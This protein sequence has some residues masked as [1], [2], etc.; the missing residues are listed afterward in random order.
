MCK[1]GYFISPRGN[2]SPHEQREDI[3][4]HQEVFLRKH[5]EGDSSLLQEEM[6]QRIC[7]ER[8]F[9]VLG[10][11]VS[12]HVQEMIFPCTERRCIGACAKRE[13]FIAP[14]GDVSAHVQR[15]DISLRRE[16][17]YLHM[18]KREYFIAPR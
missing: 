16:E 6:F 10:G 5:K 8:I 17:M 13:Y 18:P 4:L 1:R 9:I 15:E 7:K 14:R 3:S 2:V 11:D 12:A